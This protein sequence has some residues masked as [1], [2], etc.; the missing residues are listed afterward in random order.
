MK[1]NRSPR[2]LAVPACLLSCF[3]WPRQRWPK[4]SASMQLRVMS[5]T[6]ELTKKLEPLSRSFTPPVRR[7]P[8]HFST[9]ASREIPTAVSMAQVMM[10]SL[11]QHSLPTELARRTKGSCQRGVSSGIGPRSRI[12]WHRSSRIRKSVSEN[13]APPCPKMVPPTK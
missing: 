4:D 11:G 9:K 10:C 7:Q 13:W 6:Y 2:Q 12:N 3:R 8:T 5:M 1:R